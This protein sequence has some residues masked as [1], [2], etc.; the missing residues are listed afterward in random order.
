MPTREGILVRGSGKDDIGPATA[1]A[2]RMIRETYGRGPD[3]HWDHDLLNFEETYLQTPGNAFLLAVAGNEEVVGSLAVRRYDGRLPV[4]GG[5]YDV[6][7]TAEL[8]K[9]YVDRKYRRLGVG[10]RLVKEAEAFCRSAGYRVLYLHT[11][12]YLPGAFEFWQSQGFLVVLD[13]GGPAQTVHLEK[14]V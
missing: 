5:L 8:A 1:F 6:T 9:C 3:A 7:V 2:F 14:L 11:H 4:L 13:E 10:S 12:R